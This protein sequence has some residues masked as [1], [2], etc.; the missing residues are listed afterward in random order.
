[1]GRKKKNITPLGLTVGLLLLPFAGMFEY[2]KDY[3]NR[4]NKWGKYKRK[5]RRR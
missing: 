5:R 1:M 4:Q 2:T 3:V